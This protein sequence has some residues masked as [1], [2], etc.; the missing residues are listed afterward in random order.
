MDPRLDVD[1]SPS[2]LPSMD[3]LQDGDN[4][5]QIYLDFEKAFDKVD[6]GILL[7]KLRALGISGKLGLW[8]AN[9][10]SNW[11]QKV[12]I[13]NE[14]SNWANVQEYSISKE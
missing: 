1:V 11:H 3:K 5:D 14:L 2:S 8:I 7:H 6:H 12:R 4:V 13:A 10:L 9:F